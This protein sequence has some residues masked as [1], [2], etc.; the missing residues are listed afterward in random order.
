M[1]DSELKKQMCENLQDDYL[2]NGSS[3]LSDFE[4]LEKTL[5]LAVAKNNSKEIADNL[6]NEFNNL[7]S[8]SVASPKRLMQID[9][10]NEQVATYL[11]LM[12]DILARIE[13]RKNQSV[14]VLSDVNSAIEYAKNMLLFQDVERVVLITLD[15]NFRVIKSDY[16]SQ[17]TANFANVMPVEVSKRLVA[18]KPCYVVV[19]HNHLVDN[20][21]PSFSDVNFT[22]NLTN[23]LSQFGIKLLDHIIVCKSCS[24]S[25]AMEEEYKFIF[26]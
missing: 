13:L 5:S 3:D 17:G 20:S 9:G 8:V 21:E 16:I 19:A 24:T 1:T 23:W 25:M 7:K 6:M 11:S 4:L 14:D 18:E 10:V 22:I 2:L 12:R 26:D 15:E